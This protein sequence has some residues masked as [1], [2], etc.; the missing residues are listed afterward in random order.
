M[1]DP[2]SEVRVELA[3][4]REANGAKG[5]SSLNCLRVEGPPMTDRSSRL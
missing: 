5:R 4:K 3:K 2:T 1:V